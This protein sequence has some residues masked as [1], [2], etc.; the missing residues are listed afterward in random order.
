MTTNLF[1]YVNSMLKN[2]RH[3]SVSSLVETQS[4]LQ[5]PRPPGRF[6]VMC[7]CDKYQAKHLL[8]SHVTAAFKSIN[9][10][11]MNYVLMLFTL[12]HILHWGPDPRRKKGLQRVIPFQLAFLVRWT[13]KEMND[14]VEKNVKFADNMII[15]ETIV[16]TYLHLKFFLNQV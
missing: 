7:D 13:K 8:C 16:L 5:T 14:K 11:P 1:E 12:Q 9:L 4:P 10:D 2:T 3:L 15:T 6:R